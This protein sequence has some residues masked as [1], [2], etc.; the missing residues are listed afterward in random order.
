[1]PKIRTTFRPDQ[2]IDVSDHEHGELQA[3]G[4]VL[5]TTATTDKGLQKAAER[6]VAA[7][8]PQED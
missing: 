1:M 6:Q 8:T 5:D 2:E 3:L 7:N 4:V